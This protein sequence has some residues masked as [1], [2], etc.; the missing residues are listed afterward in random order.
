MRVILK[1]G[2]IAFLAIAIAGL[3]GTTILLSGQKPGTPGTKPDAA[4]PATG[5][6]TAA[7]RMMNSVPANLT[8][9][10]TL[11]WVQWGPAQTEAGQLANIRKAVSST[12]I[13][14]LTLNSSNGIQTKQTLN[15]FVWT[16]GAPVASVVKVNLALF[17]VDTGDGYSF[18][19]PS[20]DKERTLSVYTESKN[21]IGTFTAAFASGGP[22]L[23]IS[24]TH[25]KEVEG[26]VD[27]IYTVKIPVQAK[28]IVNV[29]YTLTNSS[30]AENCHLALEAATL[31]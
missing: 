26:I 9:L 31:K 8:T 27:H 16:D 23:A 17:V 20:G 24:E 22:K 18:T 28:G 29:S 15:S 1:P 30:D 14:D 10:G 12:P 4:R 11:D 2:G 3:S 19:V 21:A 6:E 13:G 5:G 7:V 25:S